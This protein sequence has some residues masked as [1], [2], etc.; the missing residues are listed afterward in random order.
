MHLQM[1]NKSSFDYCW[2]SDVTGWTTSS[3]PPPK[4][5]FA[6]EKQVPD[7]ILGH[8]LFISTFRVDNNTLMSSGKWKGI[9]TERIQYTLRVTPP[10]RAI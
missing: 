10:K 3:S 7:F 5:I 1:P 9:V 8:V 6:R 4:N 2:V